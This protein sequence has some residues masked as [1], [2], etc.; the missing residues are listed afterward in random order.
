MSALPSEIKP[1]QTLKPNHAVVVGKIDFVRSFDSQEGRLFEHRLLQA[2][3]D[4]YSSPQAV[5]VTAKNK[6]GQAGDECRV[7]VRVGGYRDSYK[8]REGD[9]VLTARVQLRAVE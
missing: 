8:N 4:E 6:L 5:L 9:Q 2:A 7:L 3:E 1:Q